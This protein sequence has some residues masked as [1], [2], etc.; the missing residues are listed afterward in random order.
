MTNNRM[1]QAKKRY[2]TIRQYFREKH[3]RGRQLSFQLSLF[4]GQLSYRSLTAA[5]TVRIIK[6]QN[7]VQ[8]TVQKRRTAYVSGELYKFT[9]EYEKLYG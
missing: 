7:T 9:R 4:F 8:N 6:V 2:Y 3:I 5:Y 1:K